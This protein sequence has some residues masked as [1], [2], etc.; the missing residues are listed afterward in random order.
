MAAEI[1]GRPDPAS[2]TVLQETSEPSNSVVITTPL[3]SQP[4]TSSARPDSYIS[5][6]DLFQDPRAPPRKSSSKGRKRGKTLLLRDTSVKKMIEDKAAAK[7]NKKKR[8]PAPLP[9]HISSDS[10]TETET[11]PLTDEEECDLPS[12]AAKVGDYV[13]VKVAGT[14]SSKNFVSVVT[15]VEEDGELYVTFFILQESEWSDIPP[16]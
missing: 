3:P 6:S 13:T 15:M 11:P 16:M 7:A 10:E 4:S 8:K 12:I 14:T 9:Q 2:N 1:T 5:P